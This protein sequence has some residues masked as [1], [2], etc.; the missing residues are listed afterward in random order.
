MGALGRWGNKGVRGQ[1]YGRLGT[2]EGATCSQ[3]LDLRGEGEAGRH[4][5]TSSSPL[6]TASPPPMPHTHF[7]PGASLICFP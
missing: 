7:L 4:L 3:K 5:P 2:P 1:G 6:P